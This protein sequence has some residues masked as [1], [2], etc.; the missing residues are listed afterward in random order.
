[1]KRILFC[2]VDSWNP[3]IASSSTNT[4][5]TLF[6]GYPHDKLAGLYLREEYP[7][8]DSC[9]VY[10]QISERKII[11]SLLNGSIKTG[12]ILH[13]DSRPSVTDAKDLESTNNL[14]AKNR[15]KRKYYKLFIREII[16]KFGHWKTKDLDEF[17]DLFKPDVVIFSLEGYIHFNRICRYVVN[18][19]GAF[20]I[21]YV[22][23][24]TFTYKQVTGSSG[25]K[26][27]RFFQRRS[28]RKTARMCN[29]FWAITPK[30]KEEFDAFAGVDCK[31][32]TK[33]LNEVHRE[34]IIPYIQNGPIK[35]L[36]TGNLAIGR[37]DTLKCLSDALDLIN[38]EK[39]KIVVDVYTNAV[40][41][42]TDMFMFSKSIFFHKPVPVSQVVELQK[43][44]DVL[45]F[46]ED[47]VGNNSKKAR[48]SFSTKITDYFSAAKCILAIGPEDIAPMV[49]LKKEDAALCVYE[50]AQIEHTLSILVNNPSKID[51][52]AEKAL[53][54]GQKNH[55]KD[56]ILN[57]VKS[58]L[59]VNFC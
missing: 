1:M 41:S 51:E 12:Q 10:Y 42:D 39:V 53:C 3:N 36:Y 48:L 46:I 54:C 2:S 27:L 52:Y 24:D 57:V 44:A 30:T 4:Y 47:I 26:L 11:R 22:W 6:A 58:S 34:K 31:I 15:K 19:T 17:L 23:D 35:V 38:K 37:M 14:Y 59:N 43:Q 29:D 55:R 18:H 33:P 50:K 49:Y 9:G 40:L 56:K 8:N 45:L 20:A 21:G 16:W 25:F 5:A 7:E 13:S 32:V 28:I